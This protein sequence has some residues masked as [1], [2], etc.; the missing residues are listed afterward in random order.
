MQHNYCA[1]WT[2]RD[3]PVRPPETAP[4]PAHFHLCF[5]TP[6][7]MPRRLQ[8][9]W[10][11]FA[12]PALSFASH[13]PNHPPQYTASQGRRASPL[14]RRG[15]LTSECRR[16][17]PSHNP[18]MLPPHSRGTDTEKS[19]RSTSPPRTARLL[20]GSSCYPRSNLV[21]LIATGCD[22]HVQ[23]DDAQI[24]VC[25]LPPL[26]PTDRRRRRYRRLGLFAP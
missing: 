2:G 11:Q 25:D 17:I 19:T 15:P 26:R 13:F 16:C 1:P 7:Q 12:E 14:L 6:T 5:G 10:G 21:S 9:Y 3:Q 22:H 20:S 4:Q 8:R 24:A 18:T 23:H